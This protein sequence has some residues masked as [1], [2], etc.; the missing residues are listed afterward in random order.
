M[1][2]KRIYPAFVTGAMAS[3][4]YK[5]SFDPSFL[6]TF[7]LNQQP[8]TQWLTDRAKVKAGTGRGTLIFAGD[9]SPCSW[10]CD[11]VANFQAIHAQ[12]ARIARMLTAAGIPATYSS[13]FGGHGAVS[14]GA[15][16]FR[17]SQGAWAYES[18]ASFGIT[19]GGE[20]FTANAAATITYRPQD[21][22]TASI[23]TSA[24][25]LYYATDP[26]QGTI[27]GQVNALATVPI[28]QNGT[29]QL[30]KTQLTATLGDNTYKAI[31]ATNGSSGFSNLIGFHCYNPLVPAI[32]CWNMAC[33]GSFAT[34]WDDTTFS[35]NPANAIGRLATLKGSISAVVFS[36]GANDVLGG[37]TTAA[38]L[39]HVVAAINKIKATGASVIVMGYN[40]ID[41]NVLSAAGQLDLNNMGLAAA[42]QTG[43]TFYDMLNRMGG[44][45]GYAANNAAGLMGNNQHRNFAGQTPCVNDLFAILAA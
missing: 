44:P 19:L 12:E 25:D 30:N 23:A 8:L 17:A 32:D 28:N 38:T 13:E 39:P 36:I 43:C 21:D 1:T 16:D 29:S 22:T 26:S 4:S 5:P 7:F 33:I 42:V 3:A 24:C 2:R 45:N 20:F 18:P 27:N 15:W 37:A 34:Q 31:W 35:W 40:P 6:S 10:F 11:N 14:L 41:T 9:S